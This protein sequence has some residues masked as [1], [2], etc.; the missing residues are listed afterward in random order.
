M[1]QYIKKIVDN[2]QKAAEIYKEQ[3]NNLN[4]E[5]TVNN[6]NYRKESSPANEEEY[7]IKNYPTLIEV[8]RME[9]FI[10]ES[11]NILQISKWK[12]KVQK[13]KVDIIENK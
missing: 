8:I 12:L 7:R 4:I 6:S 2:K 10:K 13:R 5:N 1:K 11:K 9:S 3:L